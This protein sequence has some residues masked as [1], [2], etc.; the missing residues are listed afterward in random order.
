MQLKR[1]GQISF[2]GIETICYENIETG[3]YCVLIVN[4]LSISSV[5]DDSDWGFQ[6][7]HVAVNRNDYY[8]IPNLELFRIFKYPD[9]WLKLNITI[10]ARKACLS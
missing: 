6:N 7:Q 4:W 2:C 9:L 5:S 1:K 10:T 8:L 3:K